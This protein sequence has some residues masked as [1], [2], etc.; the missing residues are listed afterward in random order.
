MPWSQTT[1]K[2]QREEFVRLARR[3]DANIAQLCRRFGISRKTG[4]KWLSREDLDDRTRR[5]HS[6]PS[7]TPAAIE[8]R[9]LAVRAEHS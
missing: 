2:Q 3:A 5:P 9:V 6:S 8:E 7:R 1:V 4:Y